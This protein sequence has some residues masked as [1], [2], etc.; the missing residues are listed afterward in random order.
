MRTTF[1]P[2]YALT[3][4]ALIGIGIGTIAWTGSGRQQQTPPHVTQDTVPEKKKAEKKDRKDF[5]KE[6]EQ[7]ERAMKELENAPDIDL[8]NIQKEIE[9]SL[10]SV[11]ESN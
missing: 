3:L 8:R 10:K 11:Q 7:I 9:E 1:K 6:L 2:G 5:D 4:V